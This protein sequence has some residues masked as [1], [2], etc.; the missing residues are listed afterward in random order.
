[1]EITKLIP[2]LGLEEETFTFSDDNRLVFSRENGFVVI[3]QIADSVSVV[4]QKL[5]SALVA[6]SIFVSA[7]PYAVYV[8]KPDFFCISSATPELIDQIKLSIW[9]VVAPF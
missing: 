8:E 2:L 9:Q 5:S 3:S 7:Y 6:G 4:V 1:M